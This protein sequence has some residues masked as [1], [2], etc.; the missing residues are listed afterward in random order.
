[1]SKEFELLTRKLAREAAAREEAEQLLEKK[2]LELYHSNEKLKDLNSNLE[3][4]VEKRTKALQETELEYSTMVESINDMIFRLDMTGKIVFTNQI[5]NKII[6]LGSEPIV[7]RN[8]L[9]FIPKEKRKQLFIH[10]ARQYLNSNCINYYEVWVYSKFNK[11]IWLR[12]NVQ[13]SSLKCKLCERKQQALAGAEEPV[14]ANQ[15]CNFDEIIIVGHDITQQKLNQDRLEKSEKRYRELTESLPELICEVDTKGIVSYANKY[16]IDKFGYQTDDILNGKFH[17]NQIFPESEHKQIAKNFNR[18]IRTRKSIPIEYLAK[19]SNGETFPVIVYTSLIFEEDQ[20]V[21][22]RGV[23]F[24]ITIRKKQEL[25]IAT[26]LKQQKFLSNI[27]MRY[28]TFANFEN[29]T[30][31]ALRLLGGHLNVS[32]VYIFEDSNDGEFTSNIFEWCNQ[33]I[34]SQIDEL[35]N[36][37][38]S[39]IPS[40]KKFLHEDGII[41]SKNITELPQDIVDILEPQGIKSILVLPLRQHEKQIG[42]IGFDECEVNHDWRESELEL[43]RTISNIIS[44]SYL[45]Q[46]IQ[47]ELIESEKENRIII[48]S[49]PDVIIQANSRGEIKALK[50]SQK[51]NLSN[52]IQG[53]DSRTIFAAFNEKIAELLYH[54]ITQCINGEKSQVEFK[55]LNWEEVEYYE[56]RLVKLNKKEVLIIVRDVTVIRQHEIQLEIAKNRAEEAS[57]MKSEFLANVSHEVRTPLNAILGFSQWLLDNTSETLH[58]SYLKTILNSGKGLLDVIN[59]ILDIS[60]IESDS[61]KMDLHAMRYKDVMSDIKSVFEIDA[62]EK[63]LNFEITTESSVPAFII[64]DE[65]R[66]YQI[67]FNLVTNAIKFTDQGFVQIS[68]IATKTSVEDEVNLMITIEDSGIGIEKEQQEK[69][70]ESFTQ[71]SGR[72]DRNYEG[73]GLGLAIANGLLKKLNGSIKLTSNLGKGST[74]RLTFLNVK[75]GEN[76]EVQ[77]KVKEGSI[78]FKLKPCSIMIVDDIDY[79]IKVLKTLINSEKVKY[80]E[81]KDGNTALAIL[82]V[83]RPDI[84]FMDIRMP[85]MD[86]FELTKIIKGDEHLK[87]IPVI[88]FSA[89]TIKNRREIIAEM[90]DDCLI[91][92]VFKKSLDPIL[93]KFIPHSIEELEEVVVEEVKN[94]EF[95]TENLQNIGHVVSVLEKEFQPKWEDIKDNLVIYEIE[96]FKKEL[97][98]FANQ[99]SCSPLTLFCDELDL[100]LNAFDI[101]LIGK[102]IEEFPKL[103]NRLKQLAEKEK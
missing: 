25:E 55:N 3:S 85:G 39:A 43:L 47:N 57:R 63:G 98:D 101:E 71:H 11:K 32:R 31:E 5:V 21:G 77:E 82:Q 46:Q 28:N 23:M 54:A 95:N 12:L 97:A 72:K 40:W 87:D 58:K 15:D 68:S 2:S 16:A 24:D 35:Q 78:K 53:Q 18:I 103:K 50:A 64:M 69:I 93:L 59:D 10:F 75:I 80:L 65:I 51:S 8:V 29:N 44:H 90:F 42:F 34:D 92:P 66:F 79:N 100:G 81:A 76:I 20:V 56:A 37:P 14:L 70:F 38:Y 6:G 22:L 41:L 61:I 4:L 96:I 27:S 94:I 45:R 67:L 74:F 13:F 89:S 49:I 7:G 102:K 73:T 48:E 83:E 52:L 62:F 17:I 1:M 86:G 9:D 30:N 33:G 60:R 99:E 19:R 91:K 88:A 36:I 84:I 26:N